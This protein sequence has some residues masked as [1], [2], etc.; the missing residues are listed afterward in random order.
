MKRGKLARWGRTYIQDDDDGLD[1]PGLDIAYL[2]LCRSNLREKCKG[3]TDIMMSLRGA[4]R[5]R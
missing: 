1:F 3:G 4:Q 2:P 5:L